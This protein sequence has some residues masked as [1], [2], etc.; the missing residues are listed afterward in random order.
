MEKG[1]YLHPRPQMHAPR[2]IPVQWRCSLLIIAPMIPSACIK[3]KCPFLEKPENHMNFGLVFQADMP[4]LS[5]F[6][7][8]IKKRTLAKL[9]YSS[10]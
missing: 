10:I 5:F 9:T 8:G 7:C 6:F 3:A 4:L 2:Q 1:L